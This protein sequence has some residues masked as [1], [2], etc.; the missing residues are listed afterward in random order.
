MPDIAVEIKS[1]TDTIAEM[2]EKAA[3]YRQKGSRLV[4]LIYPEKRLVEVYQENADIEILTLEDSLD[5]KA[6]LPNFS[7]P[8]QKLFPPKA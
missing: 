5:G 8:I 6:V 3:Y 1:P 4:W 2:R 7:L